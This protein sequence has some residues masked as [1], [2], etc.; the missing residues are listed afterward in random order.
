[1]SFLLAQEYVAGDK[2]G[3]VGFCMG[4]GLT[5]NTA[6]TSED[7]GAAVVFYGQPLK[8]EQAANV[9]APILG[10]YGSAD[11]GIPLPAVRIMADAL[12]ESDIQN[13]IHVYEGVQHAFFNDTR[14][15]YNDEAAT[16]AWSKTL[17]WFR[18]HLAG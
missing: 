17:A 15:S 10:F 11:Q 14:Q 9:Q 16:D 3:V 4:G 13:E 12:T 1:M 7:V 18:E 6:L 5:L 8:R 2:V